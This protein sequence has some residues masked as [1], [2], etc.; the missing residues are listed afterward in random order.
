MQ[1]INR[2]KLSVHIFVWP[3]TEKPSLLSLYLIKS[4]TC[5]IGKFHNRFS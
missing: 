1:T 5:M 2:I 4:N 3:V